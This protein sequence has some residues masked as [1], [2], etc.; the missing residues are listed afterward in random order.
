[1][2]AHELVGKIINI[3]SDSGSTENNHG[4]SPN[5]GKGRA[6]Y[7]HWDSSE[8]IYNNWDWH[9]YGYSDIL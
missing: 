1:M 9:K 8:K 3:R 5:F 4:K 2:T 7:K 6:E